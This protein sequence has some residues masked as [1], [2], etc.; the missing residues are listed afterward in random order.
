MLKP[1]VVIMKQTF[2]RPDQTLQEFNADLKTL[3]AEDRKWY[4][5]LLIAAGLPVDPA[6][7]D[8]A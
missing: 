3:S 8:R 7:I 5:N 4:G 6:T 2:A 1:F